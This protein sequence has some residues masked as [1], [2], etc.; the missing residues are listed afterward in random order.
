MTLYDAKLGLPVAFPK[1]SFKQ[2]FPEVLANAGLT[3]FRCA[4]TEK[5]AHVTYFF[6]GGREEAWPGEERIL[7][8]SP[9]EVGTYDKNPEMSAAELAERFCAEIG[10]DYG[11][12][13]INFANPDMVG[14]TGV[15]PAVVKAVETADACLGQV[16]DAVQAAG[17]VL[18]I[19]ADHGNAEQELQEDGS[20]HTAHTT[21]LV[22]LVV[23]EPG[24]ALREGGELSDLIPTA[25][26][27]LG[28]EKP[29]A[30]TGRSLLATSP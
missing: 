25:L 14:H 9:R 10:R 27:L 19:T 6:N 24:I 5:Y 28:L 22:P 16:V 30:M 7:V 23:T 4:E 18:L 11:F 17:G 1:E 2:I 15:I 20:P 8:P 29:A 3:Q 21:N 12:A 13:V 26:D